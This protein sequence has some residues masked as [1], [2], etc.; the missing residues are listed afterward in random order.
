MSL[1]DCA[2]SKMP[3]DVSSYF[4]HK[5]P[6]VRYNNW[7]RITLI[8][9][10]SPYMVRSLSVKYNLACPFRIKLHICW[11]VSI[12]SYVNIL[13]YYTACYAVK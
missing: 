6:L 3:K 4:P 2:A 10:L 9:V 11:V 12:V 13:G 8:N 7:L 5:K 1:N